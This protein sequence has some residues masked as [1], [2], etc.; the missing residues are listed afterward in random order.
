MTHDTLQDQGMSLSRAKVGKSVAAISQPGSGMFRTLND[1]QEI[2]PAD[3]SAL[4]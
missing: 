1:L 4:K 3:V 2:A